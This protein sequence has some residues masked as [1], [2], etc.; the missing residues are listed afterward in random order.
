MIK[1]KDFE[2]DV[3]DLKI[4][5]NVKV[6]MVSGVKKVEVERTDFGVKYTDIYK[7]TEYWEDKEYEA[8]EEFIEGC[9]A[10]LLTW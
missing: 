2:M 9:T 5:F 4:I 7:L 6:P 1:I 8:L 10:L 3:S